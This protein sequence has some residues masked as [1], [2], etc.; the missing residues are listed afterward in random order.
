M[1]HAT[2]ALSALL[3]LALAP[4]LALAQNPFWFLD[5]SP[6]RYFNAEDNAMMTEAVDAVLADDAKGAA[7]TWQNDAT[8]ASGSVTAAGRFEDEGRECRRLRLSNRA[9][10]EEA[11]STYDLC[12]IEGVWK[13]LRMPAM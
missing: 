11:T 2:V 7:R 6:A 9:R 4:G 10:G 3:L 1:R 8:G 12:R 5:Q 13:V